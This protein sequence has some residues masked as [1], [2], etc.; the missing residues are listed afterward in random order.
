[1]QDSLRLKEWKCIGFIQQTQPCG[2]F[3]N[4]IW[5]NK[6]KDFSEIHLF[7]PFSV[8]S[9][10]LV[11]LSKSVFIIPSNTRYPP[12]FTPLPP[13]SPTDSLDP[14]ENEQTLLRSVSD[15]FHTHTNT[16]AGFYYLQN[17][18]D[19]SCQRA[20]SFI[21]IEQTDVCICIHHRETR[22]WELDRCVCVCLRRAHNWTSG[23]PLSRSHRSFSVE[24][25]NRRLF[26]YR[27]WN[28]FKFCQ[29]C[30]SRAAHV[31]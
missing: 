24:N 8:H 19:S 16:H 1:M 3:C 15:L 5:V 9:V 18:I 12:Q 14:T 25:P 30:S 26:I 27:N 31:S 4:V 7:L 22:R 11:E 21:L 28:M 29:N 2:M 10:T 13:I 23:S 6:C 20:G 17:V